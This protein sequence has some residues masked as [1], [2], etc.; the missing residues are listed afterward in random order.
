M[1]ILRE[2]G[3]YG[4]AL[5]LVLALGCGSNDEPLFGP[6]AAPEPRSDPIENSAQSAAPAFAVGASESVPEQSAEPVALVLP[7][8]PPAQATPVAPLPVP[9]NEE[10]E[11][12]AAAP[13]FDPCAGNGLLFCDSFE[14]VPSG[15]FPSAAPWLP[16]LSGCGTHRVDSGLS[17]SGQNALRALAGGYP[18]CMLHADLNMEGELYI[19]SWVRLGAE[20]GLL[21]QYL[22]LLELGPRAAQDEPEL[23]IGLRPAG[24]SLCANSPGLDVSVSGLSSGSATGCSGFALQPEQWYCLQAHVKRQGRR[25]D[26]ELT[27]AGVSVLSASDVRLG[28]GW[29]D[30]QWYF[31][32]G[33]A[34]YGASAAGSVWHDD[35]AVGR[36]PLPCG[37]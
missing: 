32:L 36:E 31:K 12:A 27:V 33:R 35:V 5:L 4:S 2:N 23:R 13:P 18:E 10:A 17:V 30:R 22:S 24:G 37:L 21:D 14:D 28:N 19:R 34:S 3:R 9:P 1:A 20:P 6:I 8:T 7:A 29:D 15:T 25:L 26:Y 11:V 16:E